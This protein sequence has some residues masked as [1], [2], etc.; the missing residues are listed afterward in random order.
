MS[1]KEK[2]PTG[3]VASAGASM[4]AAALTGAAISKTDFNTAEGSRQPGLVE[5]IL[6]RE[7]ARGAAN[8]IR[9]ASLVCLAGLSDARTL[10][11]EIERERAAGALILSRSGSPGGYFLPTEG[12]A[13]KHE[14]AVYVSTL[15]A[16][17]LNTLRTIR[18][19][20]RA[21]RVLE[22]QEVLSDE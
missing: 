1:N 5:A 10:Q 14:I 13:G 16:R 19:A 22:G 12:E 8:A 3:A 21:L 20:K 15:R 9:T 11:A 2:A 4:E 6:I 17:A 18:T 7:G